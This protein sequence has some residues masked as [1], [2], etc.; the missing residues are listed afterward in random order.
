MKTS[1]IN[2]QTEGVHARIIVDGHEIKGVRGYSISHNAEG[3]P[4][5]QLS[6]FGTDMTFDSDM[7][8]ALPEPF[9]GFY[10]SVQKLIDSGLV[11]EEQVSALE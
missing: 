4:I 3:I 8:P 5:I 6:L 2:I 1:K 10:V 9:S 7:V 11:S